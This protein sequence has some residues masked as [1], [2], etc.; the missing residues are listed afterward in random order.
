MARQAERLIKAHVGVTTKV[1]IAALGSV[2]RS[3]GKARRVIDR[4]PKDRAMSEAPAMT[5]SSPPP[6]C[7]ARCGRRM[8]R[9]RSHG[10][11]AAV[12]DGRAA[13][14]ADFW[15]RSRRLLDVLPKKPRRNEAEARAAQTILAAARGTRAISRRT[16][17][18]V[19]DTLTQNLAIH[20]LEELVFAAAK[21]IPGLT[22]TRQVADES[23][24]LQSEKN[25][26]EIDQGLFL[27]HMLASEAAGRHLCHAMLLPRPEAAGHQ[28]KLATDGGVDFGKV[29]VSARARR[30]S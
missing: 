21:A 9:R 5:P 30:R 3:Q 29:S 4:R 22:P 6:D 24:A 15:A 28:Q 7:R 27:S 14:G 16:R 17:R 26:I 18:G 23:R 25:G 11:G 13:L 12:R 8:G 19:Y 2:E 20:S 1:T 10:D